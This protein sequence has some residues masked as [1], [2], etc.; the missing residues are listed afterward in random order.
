MRIVANIFISFIGAGVLGLPYAFKQG[1]LLEG[2]I[3]MS[4]VCYLAIK[5][6]LLLIDCRYAVANKVSRHTK[7]SLAENGQGSGS[8]A[9]V[10]HS[11]GHDYVEVKTFDI[12][13]DRWTLESRAVTFG[14]VA[15][16]A[17]GSTGRSVVDWSL[18]ITQVGFC[19]AYLIFISENLATFV[20]GLTQTEWLLVI[21]S[22]LF[23]LTL[24]P[25]MGNLAVFSLIGTY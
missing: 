12:D 23:L 6:L 11:K 22:P 18:V 24:I 7:Q 4:G 15:F 14:D 2:T 21:L 25:D 8:G 1:G 19:C 10:K 20:S 3:V 9:K 16:S 17:Y 5:A 13:N